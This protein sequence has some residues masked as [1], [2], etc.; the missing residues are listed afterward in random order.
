MTVEPK[1][2]AASTTYQGQT[3]WFC[4]PH[5]LARFQA[6]PA[7]YADGNRGGGGGGG[8]GPH[9]LAMAAHGAADAVA[10]STTLPAAV[11]ERAREHA[12]DPICGMMVDKATAL[13]G[14]RGGRV[15]YFCSV[16]CQRTF[17]SPEA[18]L[19]SMRTRVAVAL[20]GV[21]ALAIPC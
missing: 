6:D 11:Q 14:E 13:K 3:Y 20:T 4:S 12:K 8:H 18:E 1:T 15:Y 19:K 17:E 10:S 7:R 2:A 9:R 16:G 21:L 5:C